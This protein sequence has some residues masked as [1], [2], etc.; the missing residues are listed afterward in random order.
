MKHI[1]NS[2]FKHIPRLAVVCLALS[3][4]SYFDRAESVPVEKPAAETIDLMNGA[5]AAP[6]G[7]DVPG[8]IYDNTGGSVQV[9]P[10]D[11]PLPA[12]APAADPGPSVQVYP[13]R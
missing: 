13:L 3:S 12:P 7:P 5:Q 11:G 8:V 6:S 2:N 10:L 1:L 4:C 9:F